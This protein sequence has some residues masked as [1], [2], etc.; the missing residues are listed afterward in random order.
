MKKLFIRQEPRLKQTLRLLIPALII[1]TFI[2]G[3]STFL[4]MQ[5]AN[6]KQAKGAVETLPTGTFIINMG[7]SPQT[8]SNGLKPYGLIYELVNTFKIPVKWSI[9]TAKAKDAADFT[10]GGVNYC[11]GTFIVPG[12]LIDT[13][14]QSRLSYWMSQGVVG[15]YTNAALSVPVS[16]T[17]NSFPRIVIDTLSGNQIIIQNYF[18]NASIPSSAYSTGTPTSVTSCD[19][20]WVNPHGDPTWSSHGNLFNFA[21][22]MKGYIWSQCHSVSMLENVVNP[23]NTSQKLNFLSTTGLQCYGASKCVGVTETHAKPA[24]NPITHK[25]PGDPIMQFMGSMSGAC[26]G[27]SEQWYVPLSAGAWRSTTMRLVTTSTGVSP[28]EGVVMVYGPAFGVSTNG[29]VMYEGG[30]DLDASGTTAEKVAAQRAFFNFCLLAGRARTP[31]ISA[32]SIQSSFVAGMQ[33][34]VSVNVSGGTAPYSYQWTSS[35]NGTFGSPTSASSTFTPALQSQNQNGTITVVIT[36]A[37]NRTTIQKISIRSSGSSLPVSFLWTKAIPYE[38]GV[39]VSWATANEKNND[40][41]TVYRSLGN[42]EFMRIAEVKGAGSSTSQKSYSFH[43][44]AAPLGELLYRIAQTDYDGTTKFFEPVS[45]I[46]RKLI[47]GLMISPNPIMDQTKISF[48]AE[49]S[50]ST[51]LEMY[52]IHGKLIARSNITFVEGNNVFRW[53]R[54]D[55]LQPGNYFLKLIAKNKTPIAL[56]FIKM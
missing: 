51:E 15:I 45:V 26:T 30:H 50:G 16:M 27:G 41:F 3:L 49:E 10:F 23:L 31:Q 4:Y 12:D 13:T 52:D 25:L 33:G 32:S 29:W 36:D 9:N 35:I 1:S 38:P 56:S 47:S 42:E 8:V 18:N 5:F 53:E 21:A 54:M 39:M 28:K 43:D 44:K 22:T 24:V 55:N 7:V 6:P 17:I 48:F 46:H 19:D 20:L 40:Y 37:C 14:V 2:V 34:N 11:G